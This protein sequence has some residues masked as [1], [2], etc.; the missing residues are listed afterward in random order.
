MDGEPRIGK[1]EGAAMLSLAAGI[2][3]FQ[4]MSMVLMP[5]TFAGSTGWVALIPVAGQVLAG[6]MAFVG[7]VTSLAIDIFLSLVGL[8]FLSCWFWMKDAPMASTGRIALSGLAEFVPILNYAPAL[9]LG[10]WLSIRAAN[11]KGGLMQMGLMVTP[12]GRTLAAG[13]AAREAASSRRATIVAQAKAENRSVSAQ[14]I[15]SLTPGPLLQGEDRSQEAL[16][17][18]RR[19]GIDLRDPRR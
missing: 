9:T 7:F 10:T 14:E 17:R 13:A 16:D 5:A 8:V 18:G 11:G 19:V 15:A 3:L 4:L 6:S 12:A 2:D 1:L